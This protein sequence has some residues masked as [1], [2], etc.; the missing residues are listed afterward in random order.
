MRYCIDFYNYEGRLCVIILVMML[1]FL[2]WSSK[3]KKNMFIFSLSRED[4]KSLQKSDYKAWEAAV[5][6]SE[7]VSCLVRKC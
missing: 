2:K 5:K 1:S 4:L 3:K 6:K 7:E